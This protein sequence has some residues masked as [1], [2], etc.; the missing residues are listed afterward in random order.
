MSI[1]QHSREFLVSPAVLFSAFREPLRLA[2]WWGPSGF[3]N[4]FRT[5]EFH[6]GGRWLFT[7]HGPDGKDY[8]NESQFIEILPDSF[9]RMKHTNLP[10]F[11]VTF[12]FN[13]TEK[14]T[15]LMWVAVFENREFAEG[16]REFLDNANE[17]N[18]D[19]LE[20]EIATYLA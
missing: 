20:K 13:A 10:H 12:T 18:L 9:I 2:R 16:L 17:Q 11:E 14:G 19:R 4:T 5:F 7:M 3:T 6:A 8:E 15:F 1:F